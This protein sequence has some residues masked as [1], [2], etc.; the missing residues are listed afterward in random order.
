M[1]KGNN[2]IQSIHVNWIDPETS[3]AVSDQKLKFIGTK[4]RVELDQKAFKRAMKRAV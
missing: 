1:K 4:G 2:F 3:S